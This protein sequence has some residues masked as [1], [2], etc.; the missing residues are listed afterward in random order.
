MQTV[1]GTL[2]LSGFPQLS[3]A[4]VSYRIEKAAQTCG[5]PT[6]AASDANSLTLNAVENAQYSKDGVVWQDSPA[7][8]NLDAGTVYTLY[9]R[10]K[11]TD[12]GNYDASPSASAQFSTEYFGVNPGDLNLQ[13]QS[14]PYTGNL[15]AYQVSTIPYVIRSTVTYTVNGETTAAAPT[16]VGVYPVTVSFT[17]QAGAAPLEPIA[18]TL[19]ITKI[20]QAAPAAPRAS[21]TGT[22]SITIT[23]I[24]GA[25][26]SIDGGT[27][28]QSST[29]L[30][31]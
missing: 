17:M 26:F 5:V 21:S 18:S 27:N 12:D 10:L 14:Y 4:I 28:W 2:N 30:R 16:N 25:V 23:A 20:E 15:T 6:L 8:K 9:Q 1:S 29:I 7:F 11:A 31:G 13:P 24:P 22:N 3:S 19:T